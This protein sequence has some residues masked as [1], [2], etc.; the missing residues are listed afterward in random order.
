MIKRNNKLQKL[1]FISVASDT[2]IFPSLPLSIS[3]GVGVSERVCSPVSVP[4]SVYVSANLNV[5]SSAGGRGSAR[6]WPWV[7]ASVKC[8][9]W[10]LKQIAAYWE[11][12][13]SQHW[14]NTLQIYS[15]CPS[16]F[17]CK[18]RKS[19]NCAACRK[20]KLNKS[21]LIITHISL[22]KCYSYL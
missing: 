18:R 11:F 19:L 8:H 9:P 4:R 13:A 16:F 1:W 6:V 12:N 7:S 3:P 21:W 14:W 17:Y 10:Q 2:L 22:W 5:L 15:S 20:C